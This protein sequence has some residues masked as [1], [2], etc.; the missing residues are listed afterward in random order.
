[1]TE[2]SSR[3][4]PPMLPATTCGGDDEAGAGA[5]GNEVD[6]A[7]VAEMVRHHES[8]VEMSEIAQR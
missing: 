2:N 4:G 5:S 3:P 8:A 7:L 1:M 6:R